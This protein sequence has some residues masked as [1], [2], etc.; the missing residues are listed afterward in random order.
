MKNG[1]AALLLVLALARG[2]SHAAAVTVT[3]PAML[4]VVPADLPAG[5]I[6]DDMLENADATARGRAYDA[7]IAAS[8]FAGYRTARAAVVQYAARLRGRPDVPAFL[9]GEAAAVDRTRN[10]ARLTLP[11]TYGDAGDVAYQARGARGEEWTVII[12]A[13]GP[14]VTMLGAY[15]AAG[16]QAAVD[17]L[18]QLAA[19]V[20]R[21]LRA[22]AAA[23]APTP[24]ATP[25]ALPIHA[26]ALQITALFTT[27]GRGHPTGRFKPHS[28]V[29]W[30][31]VWRVAYVAASAREVLREWV[32]KDSS[33]LYS[34]GLTDR[35]FPG[36]NVLDDHL[37][38]AGA[39]PGTY[40][41]T[42]SI[43]VGKLRARAACSF[44]VVAP[45]P[46]A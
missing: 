33:A 23:N 41:I 18:R 30:H 36:D 21:R 40:T 24:T 14:Y 43:A 7:L 25:T 44:Q 28:T 19:L 6:G 42:L 31:A 10:A 45:S 11:D 35:V 32:R 13:D 15:A 8:A 22:A 4:L 3:D 20:E 39:V 38:L 29:Y 12:F 27:T 17:T 1:T 37:Q 2:H 16:E 34:N 5:Y 9:A 46:R 26:S